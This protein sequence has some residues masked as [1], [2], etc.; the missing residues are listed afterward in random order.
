MIM[1]VKKLTRV[2]E[3]GGMALIDPDPAMSALEVVGVY[4]AAYPELVNADIGT[5]EPRGAQLIYKITR[6]AGR[7][8]AQVIPSSR[9]PERT[10]QMR[11][12]L[13][14]FA[15]EATPFVNAIVPTKQ[16]EPAPIAAIPMM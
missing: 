14:R 15:K 2:F 5:P 3:Y 1:E 6:A 9:F 12:D 13:I 8:G 7:K 4:A 16:E 10:W 11:K